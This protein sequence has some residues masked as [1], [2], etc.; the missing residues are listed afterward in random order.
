DA[1]LSHWRWLTIGQPAGQFDLPT[2]TLRRAICYNSSVVDLLQPRVRSTFWQ[3]A[4]CFS[5]GRTTREVENDH[6]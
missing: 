6:V 1:R 5:V 2:I 3:A 4:R